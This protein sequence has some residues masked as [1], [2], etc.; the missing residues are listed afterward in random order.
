MQMDRAKPPGLKIVRRQIL[1][2][3]NRS[4]FRNPAHRETIMQGCAGQFE[5]PR[6]HSSSAAGD[7]CFWIRFSV[8]IGLPNAQMHRLRNRQQR[9][10]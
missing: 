8:G 4:A 10:C 6:M 9:Q 7:H 5:I 2:E 3:S 1:F